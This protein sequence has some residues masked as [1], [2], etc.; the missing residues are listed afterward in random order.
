MFDED[1]LDNSILK[2]KVYEY[3]G[4]KKVFGEIIILN[5]D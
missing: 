5:V 1:I 4:S 2:K 3:L